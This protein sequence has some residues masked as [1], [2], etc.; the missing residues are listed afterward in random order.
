[1][2]QFLQRLIPFVIAGMIIVAFIFGLMLLA[3]LILF[4][5]IVG[6][7]LF[8]IRAIRDRFFPRTKIKTRKKTPGRIIDSN[9]WKKL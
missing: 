3:Y 6:C 5:I 7:I 1:M 8:V 4:G 2:R 9:D